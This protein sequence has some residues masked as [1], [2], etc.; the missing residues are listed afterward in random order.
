MILDS[1][2]ADVVL[3]WTV[4]QTTD[5][6]RDERSDTGMLAFALAMV[7][8]LGLLKRRLRPDGIAA[9]SHAT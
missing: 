5:P 1:L 2:V 7:L 6:L 3:R 8:D 4:G 9:G